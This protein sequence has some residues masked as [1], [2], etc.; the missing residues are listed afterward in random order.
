MCGHSRMTARKRRMR[1]EAH[2]W[3][4][5]LMSRRATSLPSLPARFTHLYEH[6]VLSYRWAE[7]PA[8]LLNCSLTHLGQNYADES[9][10]IHPEFR[11]FAE[12]IETLGTNMRW[13]RIAFAPAECLGHSTADTC[14][15]SVIFM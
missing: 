1:A 10:Q 13:T 11:A 5:E 4:A 15:V 3:M 9:K 6:F 2:E 14:C 7:V 12:S 8:V